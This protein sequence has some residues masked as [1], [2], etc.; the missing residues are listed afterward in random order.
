MLMIHM[1]HGSQF[2]HHG[3]TK[4]RTMISNDRLGYIKPSNYVIEQEKFCCLCVIKIGWHRLHP[5]CEI[6]HNHY[7]VIVPVVDGGLHVVK[8]MPHLAK[9]PTETT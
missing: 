1:E 2:K 6:V 4:M 5:F 8:S 3:I 7:N 9:G